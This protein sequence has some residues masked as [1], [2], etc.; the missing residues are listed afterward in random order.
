MQVTVEPT[1]PAAPARILSGHL[2]PVTCVAVS[3]AGPGKPAEELDYTIVSASEDRTVIGWDSRT[4]RQLRRLPQDSVV[5]AVAC[6]GEGAVNNLLVIGGTD[7]SVRFLDLNHLNET[8]AT[9]FAKR[10]EAV[11]KQEE[12]DKAKDDK[13]KFDSLKKERDGLLHEMDDLQKQMQPREADRRHQ[14]A[15]LCAAFSTDG[16]VCATSG[17]DRTIDLWDAATGKL[18][19]SIRAAHRAAVTSLQFTPSNQLVSAG[20][21]NDLNVWNVEA[22]GRTTK[23]GD[24]FDR[25]GGEVLQLGVSPD[26]KQ[27]LFDQGKE[28][29]VLSLARRK[30]EGVLQNYGVSGSFTHMALFAPNGKTILTASAAEG[31]LQ[32]WRT[33]TKDGRAGELRQFM[34]NPNALNTCG[35]FAPNSAFV[36]TG[37]QDHKVLVWKMPSEAEIND[38]VTGTV[39]RVDRSLNAGSTRQVPIWVD[40]DNSDPN[41]PRRLII[42]SIA[43]IVVPPAKP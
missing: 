23:A 33:P 16:T 13:D 40:V 20:R 26:G 29:L 19:G 32:L 7:G 3:K 12:M 22:D 2:Q 25:R 39:S 14:G 18:K 9:Y 5:R 21:D 11:K 42:G 4:G 8:M 15:V 28:L 10:A 35:A 41:K 17:D 34:W 31:R 6:T 1:T 38:K 37:T 30:A 27:V 24:S 43:T 36:V